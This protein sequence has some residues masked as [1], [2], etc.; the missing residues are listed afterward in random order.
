MRKDGT[1]LVLSAG[2]M[3]GAYQAGAWK[4]IAARTALSGVIGASAGALNAW[5]I[6]GGVDPED[7]AR[8]W[9]EPDCA[10]LSLFKPGLHGL[11]DGDALHS[12]IRNLHAAFHPRLEVGI[13]ATDL[14]TLRPRLFR[15]DEITWLH[16]AASC[17]VLFCYPQVRL[18]GRRFTDGGLTAPL[19]LWAAPETGAATAIG[20]NV[21][22]RAPSRIAGAAV[23]AFR[24]V[25]PKPPSVPAAFPVRLIEPS[26]QL[27]TLR[28]ALVW[29]QAV[30][31]RCIRLGESDALQCP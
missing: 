2:G 10:R 16:L 14:L 11:F 22:A 31:E 23:R 7:L 28:E 21:L 5:A 29:K 26:E 24:A 3:F 20:V 13:V 6:A 27:G 1:A 8:F 4:A 30:V 18:G 19:P 12:R 15:N 17:A 25:A 9:L